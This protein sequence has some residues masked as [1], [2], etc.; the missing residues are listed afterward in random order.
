M[1][2]FIA[3]ILIASAVQAQTI[4]EDGFIEEGWDILQA[5]PS[6]S[7]IDFETGFD[8]WQFLSP[9]QRRK[10]DEYAQTC[11][12]SHDGDI[13]TNWFETQIPEIRRTDEE[14]MGR[15][16]LPWFNLNRNY[17]VP[18]RPIAED[19]GPIDGMELLGA[20]IN[21]DLEMVNF[22]R[23]RIKV[24]EGQFSLR[25]Q[26]R[27]ARIPYKT[28]TRQN[29][30][31][32]GE[33]TITRSWTSGP[34]WKYVRVRTGPPEYRVAWETRTIRFPIVEIEKELSRW[35]ENTYNEDNED[36]NGNTEGNAAV[37]ESGEPSENSPRG[38][39]EG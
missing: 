4:N 29:V 39:D 26:T 21:N 14:Y 16:P 11:Y 3:A 7:E 27:F 31:R 22:I 2:T 17:G 32:G 8:A 33:R 6:Q 1:R 30:R 18:E 38:S 19:A 24:S 23:K 10:I 34:V 20:M 37:R 25:L 5:G 12:R 9:N 15:F 36:S 13:W 35:Q 28:T